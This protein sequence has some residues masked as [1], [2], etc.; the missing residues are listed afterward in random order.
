MKATVTVETQKSSFK[1]F[2]LRFWD[3]TLAKIVTIFVSVKVWTLV[4]VFHMVYGIY[5]E[6]ERYRMMVENYLYI[7]RYDLIP[8]LLK[9]QKDLYDVANA[10]LVGA[11]VVIVLSRDSIKHA[12]LKQ[13]NGNVDAAGEPTNGNAD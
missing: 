3:A 1:F 7:S 5:K 2:S 9:M 6:A 12:Q 11:I 13:S 8:Q 10:M 4:A